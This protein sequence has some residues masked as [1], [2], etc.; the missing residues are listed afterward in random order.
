[1]GSTRSTASWQPLP[2]MY[3]GVVVHPFHP[4]TSPVNS[5]TATSTP[6]KGSRNRLSW[7][8]LPSELKAG[9]EDGKGEKDNPY[10]IPLDIGDEFFA[11]EEYR[12]TIEEDGKGEV[13]YRG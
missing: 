7:S 13:W 8:G 4:A 10:E 6:A 5:P 11:F 2:Y 3:S 1:M 9:A 12:C